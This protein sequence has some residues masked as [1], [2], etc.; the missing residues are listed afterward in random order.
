MQLRYSFFWNVER[1]R[2]VA[3]YCRFWTTYLGVLDL[4][5]GDQY[6]FHESQQHTKK[7]RR[8]TS[9]KRR[10]NVNSFLNKSLLYSHALP[11]Y[12]NAT[13]IHSRNFRAHPTD[14]LNTLMH[15]F[16]VSLVTSFDWTQYTKHLFHQ[17]SFT[18]LSAS[19]MR[20]KKYISIDINKPL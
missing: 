14:G 3:Y 18:H 16:S 19:Q 9:Q 15:V 20:L 1:R 12:K 5:K 10:L 8:A 13:N 17:Y 7:Q 11:S 2:F 4:S 6:V